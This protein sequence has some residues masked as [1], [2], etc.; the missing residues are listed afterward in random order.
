MFVSK[1][2]TKEKLEAGYKTAFEQLEILKLQLHVNAVLNG[3]T[4]SEMQQQLTKLDS[5]IARLE[6]DYEQT[7]ASFGGSKQSVQ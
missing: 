5:Q 4:P 2:L 7:M 1:Y 3:S 6:S